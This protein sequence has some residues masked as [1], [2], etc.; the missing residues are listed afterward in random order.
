MLI[1]NSL[2]TLIVIETCSLRQSWSINKCKNHAD[3]LGAERLG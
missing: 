3:G 2:R 1:C